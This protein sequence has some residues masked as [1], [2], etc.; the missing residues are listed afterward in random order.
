MRNPSPPFNDFAVSA[1]LHPV[2]T[3]NGSRFEVA[4]RARS[5]QFVRVKGWEIVNTHNRSAKTQN[6]DGMDRYSFLDVRPL[7]LR[8]NQAFGAMQGA[9]CRWRESILSIA[10]IAFGGSG[11]EARR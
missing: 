9:F 7:E 4:L 5:K 8:Q 6:P 10:L 11:K 1:A 2:R 3:A